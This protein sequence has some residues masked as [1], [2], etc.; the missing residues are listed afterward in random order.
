M[1]LLTGKPFQIPSRPFCMFPGEYSSYSIIIANLLLLCLILHYPPLASDCT[2]GLLFKYTYN[3]KFYIPF[4][5]SSVTTSSLFTEVSSEI[6]STTFWKLIFYYELFNFT[7][8]E[9][10][11]FKLCI[12]FFLKT[13]ASNCCDPVKPLRCW[14][15]PV[16][17]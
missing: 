8:K 1:S 4:S 7:G 17:L 15:A 11:N 5:L 13:A 10:V 14:T 16:S 3:T 6:F 9:L 2:T 12:F